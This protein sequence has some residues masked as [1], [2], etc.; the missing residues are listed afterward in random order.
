MNKAAYSFIAFLTFVLIFIGPWP[1]DNTPFEA[2]KYAQQTFNEIDKLSFSK[3]AS[4]IKAGYAKRDITPP[5]GGPIGGYSARTPKINTGSYESVFVKAVTIKNSESS[6]TIVNSETLLPLPEFVIAVTKKSGLQRRELFFTSTHTHSGPGGYASGFIAKQTLG[7]FSP[8]YFSFLVDKTTEAILESRKTLAPV[9]LNYRNVSLSIE[10]SDKLLTNQLQ[11]KKNPYSKLQLLHIVSKTNHK[12]VATLVTFS[13]HPTF[14]G[15]KNKKISGDYPALLTQKIES[16]LGGGAIFIPGAVGGTLAKINGGNSSG[17]PKV[18]NLQRHEYAQALFAIVR[19]ALMENSNIGK[20]QS[21][22]FSIAT[23]NS[24]LLPVELPQPNFRISDN[25]RLS[26]LLV[27][28]I[29][30]GQ[31]SYIQVLTFGQLALFAFPADY[32]G[33]LA[34]DLDRYAL[35]QGISTWVTSFNGDYLGYLTPSRL[36]SLNHHITRDNNIYGPFGGDYFNKVS[37]KMIN[38]IKNSEQKTLR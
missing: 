34:S 28:A 17:Q 14:F 31:S 8:A 21:L 25:F 13:A 29:F 36:Y 18:S 15:Q 9:E 30:H 19:S 27:N 6:V 24:L 37:K 3:N 33:E 35:K 26:P 12:A 10:L 1:V 20:K 22:T 4:D 7:D 11:P 32:S 16:E 38:K 5:I 23:I 2:T